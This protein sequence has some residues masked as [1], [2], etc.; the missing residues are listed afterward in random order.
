[1]R[2]KEGSD[3]DDVYSQNL[4]DLSRDDVANVL[5]LGRG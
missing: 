4:I 2:F 3:D 5:A 1:M